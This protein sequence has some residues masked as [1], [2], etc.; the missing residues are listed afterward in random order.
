MIYEVSDEDE[1]EE[2]AAA[3]AAER[4]AAGD[5]NSMLALCRLVLVCSS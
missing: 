2:E 1:E 4:I 5:R 3:E